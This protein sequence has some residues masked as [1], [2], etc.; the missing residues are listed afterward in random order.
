MMNSGQN[1]LQLLQERKKDDSAS[2]PGKTLL[3]LVQAP[4]VDALTRLSLPG[5][6][7]RYLRAF[8]GDSE[9]WG[10]FE[11][12]TRHRRREPWTRM[13]STGR[14]IA[15]W[16][17]PGGRK[18]IFSDTEYVA[19]P[20]P[21]F[22]LQ[23]KQ[24]IELRLNAAYRSSTCSSQCSSS[25]GSSSKCSSSSNGS[26]SSGVNGI[27]E[28]KFNYCVANYY[29]DGNCGVNWHSDSEAELVDEAPIVCVSVGA[30]RTLGLRHKRNL[31]ETQIDLH[32]GSL[33]LM[34]GLTQMHYLHS[35]LKGGDNNPRFSLT[36]R[37]H[38]T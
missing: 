36:F 14:E 26:S 31:E 4:P 34:A 37:V 3:R 24:Q 17:E 25:H 5:A 19:Q 20:F 11:A 2:S 29:I 32:H 10:L 7:V 23:L 22:V 13:S 16:S 12:L 6:D 38:T 8:L 18:Y 33:F 35:I 28:V 9:A 27:K 15:Q 1:L 30:Q 21:Q